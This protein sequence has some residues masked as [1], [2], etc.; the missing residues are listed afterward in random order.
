M[1]G[2]RL[3]IDEGLEA[4]GMDRT[5]LGESIYDY[6]EAVLRT[7]GIPVSRL[8]RRRPVDSAGQE[9]P[10][11]QLRGV[12]QEEFDIPMSPYIRRVE[13]GLYPGSIQQPPSQNRPQT[14]RT[15]FHPRLLQT[16]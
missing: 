3:R 12:P 13:S 2:M 7:H 11:C 8:G 14:T 10:L 9:V 6:G 16:I 1:P 5:E 15:H 4:E